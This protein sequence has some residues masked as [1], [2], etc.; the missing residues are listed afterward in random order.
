MLSSY[1]F[2]GDDIPIVRAS[3]TQAIEGQDTEYGIQSIQALLEAADSFIPEPEREFDKPF[4]M[5]IGST[6]YE[7]GR[8]TRVVGQVR[9]GTIK[10]GQ[11]VELVGYKATST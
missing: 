7:E 9:K 2:P 6:W 11:P 8:G 5:S 1:E 4:F 3:A 10:V